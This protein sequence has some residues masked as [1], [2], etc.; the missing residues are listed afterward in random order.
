MKTLKR[1]EAYEFMVKNYG[2]WVSWGRFQHLAYGLMRGVPYAKMERCA[3]DN[4]LSDCDLW[5]AVWKAGCFDDLPYVEG[6]KSWNVPWEARK[7]VV[8]RV[9]WIKKTPRVKNVITTEAAQ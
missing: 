5:F 7:R 1:K 4:P 6:T 9:V 2:P 3:N 8:E